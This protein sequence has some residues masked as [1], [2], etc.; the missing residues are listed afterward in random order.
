MR[1]TLLGTGPSTGVPVVGCECPICQSTNSKNKRLRS[2]AYVEIGGK[3]ILIDTSP[4]LRQQAIT[5]QIKQLDA[6]LYTHAH[7][8]HCHGIDELR[9][10]NQ[11]KGG[12]IPAYGD[13]PTMSELQTRFPFIF[14][15][16]EKGHEHIRSCLA[17]NIF[18][19]SNMQPF[20]IEGISVIPFPQIHGK[21]WQS[22]GYRIGNFA[23]ST[24]ANELSEA[25]LCM[26]EGIDLWVVDCLRY[27]VAPTHAHV[28]LALEWIARVRPKRAILT[29]MAH[30]IEYEA[31]AAQ[32]PDGVVPGYDGMCIEV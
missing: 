27:E 28:D 6:V 3:G 22:V 19:A 14:K 13:V 25:A 10:F 2:S 24:D 16:Y 31:L 8:D 4:D 23:Y 32:L 5:H 7:A 21:R 29:H 17:A 12:P 1:I 18:D 20:E 11:L 9:P 15:A 30:E 26:L